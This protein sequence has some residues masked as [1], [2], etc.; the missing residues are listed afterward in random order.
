MSNYYKYLNMVFQMGAIIGLTTWLGWYLDK[1]Y[2][3]ATPYGT[4]CFSL[5]GV[6]LALYLSIKDFIAPKKP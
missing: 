5:L 4:V 3:L 2:Q 6:A 1:H